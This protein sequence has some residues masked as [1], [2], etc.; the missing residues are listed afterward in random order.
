MVHRPSADT[1]ALGELTWS[2]QS[3]TLLT[4]KTS[5]KIKMLYLEIIYFVI[6]KMKERKLISFVIV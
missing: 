4:T 5:L 1:F 2:G 3:V 6:W